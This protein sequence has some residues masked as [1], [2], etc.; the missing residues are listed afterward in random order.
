[1]M[2]LMT[3]IDLADL[4]HTS[5][6]AIYAKVSRGELPY[7]KFGEGKSG[8]IRFDPNEIARYLD[9]KRVSVKRQEELR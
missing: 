9:A 5:E 2:R 7:M 6:K 1:M 8:S 4:L 3:V